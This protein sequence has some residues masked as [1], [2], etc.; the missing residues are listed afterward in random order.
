MTD[1]RELGGVDTCLNLLCSLGMWDNDTTCTGVDSPGNP[2]MAMRRYAHNGNRL[3]TA[4]GAY[5]L[6]LRVG[7]SQCV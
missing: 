5:G 6:N 3:P 4:V 7:E 2:F 1:W